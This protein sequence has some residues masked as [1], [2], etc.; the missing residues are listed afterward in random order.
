M[1]I[2]SL[3]KYLSYALS[4]GVWKKNVQHKPNENLRNGFDNEE[5][6]KTKWALYTIW[7]QIK[8]FKN[9]NLPQSVQ[10]SKKWERVTK[11]V[12]NPEIQMK[13]TW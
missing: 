7:L 8:L 3:R 4:T 1:G 11:D 13:M 5:T 6:Q 2:M 9:E 12:Q 10:N